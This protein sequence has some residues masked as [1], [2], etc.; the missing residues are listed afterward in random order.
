MHEAT[1]GERCCQEE[2]EGEEE[3]KEETCRPA[4]AAAPAISP[5]SNQ[6]GLLHRKLPH[7]PVFPPEQREG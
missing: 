6:G 2:E 1:N 4:A 5:Q 3:E 7:S